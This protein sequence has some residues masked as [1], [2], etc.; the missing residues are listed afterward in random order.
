MSDNSFGDDVTINVGLNLQNLRS[1]LQ[2]AKQMLKA[3]W[4]D[5]TG[6]QVLALD[7][8]LKELGSTYNM[9][10]SQKSPLGLPTGFEKRFV[11]VNSEVRALSGNMGMATKSTKAGT[12]ALQRMSME[13]NK[14]KHKFQGWAMSIMFAGM[15]LQ[16]MAQSIW[17]F[18]TKTFTDIAHSVEGLTTNTDDLNNTW[19]YLGF[20]IGQALDP[21][22]EIL[23]PIVEQIADWVSQNEEL[24]AGLVVAAAIFGTLFAVIG[25]IVLAVAGFI[26]AFSIIGPAASSAGTAISEAFT[27][28]STTLGTGFLATVGLIVGAIAI[29]VAAWQTNLG[30]IQDFFK[31]TFMGIFTVIS[32]VFSNII[33]IFGGFFKIIKGVLSGDFSLIWEGLTDIVKNAVAGILKLLVGIGSAVYN[34]FMFVLN[35]IRDGFFNTISLIIGAIQGI[36]KAANNIPGVEIDTSKFDSAIKGI[37]QQKLEGRLEYISSDKVAEMVSGID[38]FMG[39]GAKEAPVT[40]NQITNNISISNP[41]DSQWMELLMNIKKVS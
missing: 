13:I 35:V 18:G 21:V 31:E 15:A 6:R 7:N 25:S 5:F 8:Q 10:S 29:I 17:N 9:L 36:I 37:Q 40:N 39:T 19:T 33:K 16:R 14:Q 11:D 2:E 1:Q 34:I 3:N 22:A 41:S 32:S 26:E 20:T 23:V 24:V 12:M 27:A 28:V 4:S 38:G 30:G